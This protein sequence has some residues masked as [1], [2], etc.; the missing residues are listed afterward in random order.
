MSEYKRKAAMIW[1]HTKG[2]V[3]PDNLSEVEFEKAWGR[4]RYILS[5]KDGKITKN[6]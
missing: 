5:D 6:G 2:N 4:L 3:E 1:F